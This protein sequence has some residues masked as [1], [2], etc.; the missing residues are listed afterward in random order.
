[1]FKQFKIIKQYN[2]NDNNDDY[3]IINIIVVILLKKFKMYINIFQI[4]NIISILKRKD[5]KRVTF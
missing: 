3:A 2:V 4:L 5:I 1:M